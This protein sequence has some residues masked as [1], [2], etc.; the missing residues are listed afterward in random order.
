MHQLVRTRNP[1]IGQMPAPQA[2]GGMSSLD[3]AK[4]LVE[5]GANLNARMTKDMNDGARTRLVWKDCTP[6]LLAAKASDFEMMHFLVEHGADPKLTNAV[7]STVLGLASGLAMYHQSEDS[8]T[9]EASL[10]AVKY[11]LSLGLDVNAADDDG[12]TPLHGAAARDLPAIAQVLIDHGAKVDAMNKHKATPV[13]IANGY[14]I[15][16]E[17]K[18]RNTIGLLSKV[19]TERGIPVVLWPEGAPSIEHLTFD[20]DETARAAVFSFQTNGAA[21]AAAQKV[22]EKENAAGSP[23]AQEQVK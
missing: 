7:H 22:N 5:H 2:T 15:I 11:A 14:S 3:L 21:D 10:E 23:A 19:M 4:K 1:N 16:N 17:Q 9:D 8:G 12:D 20:V 13:M 18:H 6:L